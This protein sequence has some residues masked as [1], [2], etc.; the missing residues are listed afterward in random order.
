MIADMNDF[1][2]NNTFSSM[3]PYLKGKLADDAF[4]SVPYEKGY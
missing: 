4:S 3:F 1:G 2:W